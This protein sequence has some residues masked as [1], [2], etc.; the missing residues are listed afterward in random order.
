VE[1]TARLTR[2]CLGRDM[3][4]SWGAGE[5]SMS[6]SPGEIRMSKSTIVLTVAVMLCITFAASAK[7]NSLPNI[8][9]RK[10]C[11]VRAKAS[12]DM[13]G[14][15]STSSAFDLC[16]KSE[17]EARDALVSSWKDIPSSY[18]AFC[19]AP[20][21]YSPS[22]IEWISCLEMNIDVKRQRTKQ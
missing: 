13:M 3:K 10:S 19:I 20:N 8:D 9:I 14:D 12:A 17:Q 18:K 16:M 7:D 11:G 1:A 5:P 4:Q 22:Y 15:K 21:A 6:C 2:A